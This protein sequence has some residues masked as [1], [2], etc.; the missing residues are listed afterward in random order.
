MFLSKYFPVK[1]YPLK[2]FPRTPS[3]IRETQSRLAD[4][5]E[6]ISPYKVGNSETDDI[7]KDQLTLLESVT[8]SR[9]SRLNVGFT[10]DELLIFKGYIILDA[11]TTRDKTGTMA[12]AQV[13]EETVKDSRWK[14]APAATTSAWLDKALQMRAEYMKIKDETIK[15]E[16]RL[17]SLNFVPKGV[18]R[19]DYNMTGFD[20]TTIKQYGDPSEG[21]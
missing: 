21:L 6:L 17:S 19:C 20:N 11:W 1:Y 3:T 7:S 10:G 15:E 5:I 12:G 8:A 16:K 18:S 9:V 14:V 2:Y 13:L 4:V